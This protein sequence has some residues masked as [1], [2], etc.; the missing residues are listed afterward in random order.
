MDEFF[1]SNIVKTMNSKVEYNKQELCFDFSDFETQKSYEE[2]YALSRLLINLLLLIPG[3]YPNNPNMGVNIGKYEF[4]LVT[5]Q[6]LAQI[7][8]DIQTQINLYIPNSQV[9]EIV[10][11]LVTDDLS[12]TKYLG[13]GFG[14]TKR[15]SYPENLFVFF[16]QKNGQIT[17]K[18]VLQE[19]N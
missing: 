1:S 12:G 15:N 3:T 8:D 9:R 17:Y 14:I 13:V 4:E 10:V 2:E 5:G 16:S 19:G 7:K 6:E 18:S 11:E